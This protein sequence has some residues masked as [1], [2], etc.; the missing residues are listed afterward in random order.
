MDLTEFSG[1]NLTEMNVLCDKLADLREDKARLNAQLKEINEAEATIEAKILTFLDEAGLQS[2][3]GARGKVSVVNRFTVK[4]PQ[5]IDDKQALFKYLQARKI[6]YELV[7]VNSQTLNS[8]Y[9][10]EM[11]I[12]KGE[13]NI[14]FKIPGIGEPGVKQSI[15]FRKKGN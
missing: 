10:Q 15:S 12:A 4:V 11:E 6:F 3:D 8:F 7:S 9:K 1:N 5:S 2:F 14:D 13:G